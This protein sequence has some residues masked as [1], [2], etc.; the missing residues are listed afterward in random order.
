MVAWD[1]EDGGYDFE[2][3]PDHFP[4]LGC[5]PFV[6]SRTIEQVAGHQDRV[7]LMLA[8]HLREAAESLEHGLRPLSGIRPEGGVRGAEVDVCKVQDTHHT[9]YHNG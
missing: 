2:Q 7:H 1:Q 8:R 6:R 4:G 3:L 5:V 9:A